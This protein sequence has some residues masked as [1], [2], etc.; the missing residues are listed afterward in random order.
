M[1]KELLKPEIQELIQLHQWADLRDVLQSWSPAEIADLML[2]V[3]KQNRVLLYRALQRDQAYEVFAYLDSEQQTNLLLEL[4]DQE[5]RELLAELNPDDR[6]EL[7]EEL[8]GNVTRNLLTLL[9]PDDLREARWLLGYPEESIGRLMTPEFVA[10]RPNWTVEKA[11]EHIKQFGIDSEAINR[12]YVRDDRGVLLDDLKL[13]KVILA[14]NTTTI[15]ELMTNT[16]VSLSAFDDQEQAVRM[17][18]KYDLSSLPVVDS[19]GVLVGIVTF[20]DVL[21]IAEQEAT[22]DIQKLGGM[23]ALDDTYKATSIPEMIKKRVGWLSILMVSEMLTTSVLAYFEHE[24]ERAAVLALFIPLI[25]SSG[26]NSGS[27]AATL[28]T[29]ALAL[30]EIRLR[31]W[32]FVC[33]REIITGLILG[34]VLGVLGFLRIELASRFGSTTFGPHYTMV[35]LTVGFS[36]IGIVLWGTFIGSMLPFALKKMKFDPATSS[37]PFVATLVDVIGIIIYFIIATIVLRGTLL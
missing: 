23:E 17:M 6:T 8:P 15:R 27:Q 18:E 19:Q 10:I 2:D 20:D 31:D 3:E 7:L 1:L 16:V 30:E 21:D 26:G 13:R 25:I 29:R 12:I 32:I 33:R 34:G 37:A 14:D 28:I 24:I 9:S 36:L 4:T 22:E 5:T 11:I 35:G